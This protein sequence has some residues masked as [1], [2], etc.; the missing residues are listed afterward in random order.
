MEARVARLEAD[1]DHVKRSVD[2]IEAGVGEIKKT[3]AEFRVDTTKA[4]GESKTLIATL[5]ERT[6][7]FPTRWETFIVFSVLIAVLGTFLKFVS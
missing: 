1:M 3:I 2:R 4:A 7:N 5:D 6:K